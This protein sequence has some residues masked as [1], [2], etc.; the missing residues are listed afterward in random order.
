MQ[1][2]FAKQNDDIYTLSQ[3]QVSTLHNKSIIHT[4]VTFLLHLLLL[5]WLRSVK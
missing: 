1:S 3:V 4:F 2:L 5:V